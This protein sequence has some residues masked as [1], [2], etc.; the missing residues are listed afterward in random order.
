MTV[1]REVRPDLVEIA[2]GRSTACH[3]HMTGKAA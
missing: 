2:P 1:C 3:L